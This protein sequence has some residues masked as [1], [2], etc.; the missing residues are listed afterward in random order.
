MLFEYIVSIAIGTL[1]VL[2][3]VPLTLY[4]N[5]SFAGI[6]NYLEVV[7]ASREALQ[8]ERQ[9]ALLVGQRQVATVQLIK[10][11]GGGWSERQLVAQNESF[12]HK[13]DRN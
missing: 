1:V 2:V 6:V 4:S 8:S 10:A 7:D 11:L 3:L 5:R 12:S 9:N 13:A